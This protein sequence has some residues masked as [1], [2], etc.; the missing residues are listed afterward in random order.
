MFE[1]ATVKPSNSSDT[2]AIRRLPGGSWVATNTSL[3]QLISWAYNVTDERLAGAPGWL[4]SARFDVVAHASIED[5][6]LDQLHLMVQSLLADRF[7]LQVHWEQR[8]LP[9]YRMEVVSGGPKV[10]AL[11]KGT[12]VSQD[13]FNMTILGRLSGKHVTAP[14]LAKILTNQLGRYVKDDTGFDSVF[15]FTLVWRPEGVSPEDMPPDDDRPSIFTAIRE[16]LG[17]NLIPDKGPV[18][19]I[20]IDHVDQRPTAN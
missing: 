14:M 8:Q 5:P 19:V 3:R 17:F 16:Q 11:D 13:P 18:E 12:E 7:H 2:V 15:N 6:T 4:N 10:R 9:F 20:A 1:V